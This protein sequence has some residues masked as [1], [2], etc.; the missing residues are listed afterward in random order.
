MAHH[1]REHWFPYLGERLG[2]VPFS[3]DD[4]TK[5][6]W[7]NN[8][9]AWALHDPNADYHVVIQDDAIVCDN[10]HERAREFIARFEGENAFQFFYGNKG[11]VA[12][13][14]EMNEALKHTGFIRKRN[15]AWGVAICLPIRH[16]K[17]LAEYG[18][19]H[20]AWQDDSKI[21]GYIKTAKL[22]VIFPI[23]CL[24]DH[25]KMEDNKTLVPSR[26]SSRYSDVFIDNPLPDIYKEEEFGAIP[27]TIHQI[28]I[29]DQ[30]KRPSELMETW[31][32]EGWEYKLWTEK[33]IDE[34]GLVNRNL[35]D[36]YI[37]MGKLYGASDVARIEILERFG[38]VYIDADSKRL[39]DISPLLEGNRF[40]AVTESDSMGDRIANG[41]IGSVAHHPI[42]KNYILKMGRAPRIDPPWSTIG[43][44][45][46]TKMVKRHRDG[47]TAIFPPHTFYPIDSRGNTA[48]T[49]GVVYS[50]H[51][52]GSTHNRYGNI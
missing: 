30:T 52:W 37:E 19:R 48:R 2:D 11:H 29:G 7:Q 45:L 31:K 46:F 49:K 12:T 13:D 9:D 39:L 28:W 27:K 43:G 51:F 25:R 18:N 8:K 20:P 17:P 32:Q 4:G 50:E 5:G 3:V 40:F 26:D 22:P 41:V 1:K 6:I 47:F 15:L 23:P 36:K 21:D 42:L 10:F 44:T 34:L 24:I 38:G 14:K 33:E 16:I 35:Y